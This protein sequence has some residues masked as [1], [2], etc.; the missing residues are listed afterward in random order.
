MSTRHFVT[1]FTTV[2]TVNLVILALAALPA[3]AQSPQNNAEQL[4][5]LC[6]QYCDGFDLI[7]GNSM[8]YGGGIDQAREALATLQE[9]EQNVLPAVQPLLAVFVENYGATSMEVSN[10]FHK[11]GIKLDSNIGN[12]FDELYRGVTNVDSSRKASADGIARRMKM[13]L[14]GAKRYPA[15]LRLK[16]MKQSKELL[17]IGQQ[18]DPANADINDMLATIDADIQDLAVAA[19]KAIDDAK[20]AGNIGSF[21]GPGSTDSLAKAALN[22]FKSHPNWTGKADKKVEVLKVAVRG[23]WEVAETDIFGRTISWRLPIHLAITDAKLKP[24]GLARVYELSAVT[25]QGNPGA[26]AKASPF[27]AYWVG[28]SWQMRIKNLR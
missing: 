1:S 3:A 8:Y 28:N 24:R 15:D 17:V 14:D 19:E 27:A 16:K 11:A 7:H 6:E 20:W 5:A 18:M 10:Y 21:A 4:I 26:T 13:D 23:N 25:S 22:F 12:R 9:V 2:L